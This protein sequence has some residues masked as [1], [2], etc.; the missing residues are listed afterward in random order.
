MA[1]PQKRTFGTNPYR[2]K[3]VVSTEGGCTEPEYFAIADE[4]AGHRVILAVL[5]DQKHPSPPG[6]LARMRQC[7]IALRPGDGL[8]C[9]LD[10]DHWTDAQLAEARAWA[11]AGPSAGVSRHLALSNPKFELWL[12]LHFEEVAGACGAAECVTRL[13]RHLPGYDKHLSEPDFPPERIRRAVARASCG[14]DDPPLARTGTNVHVLVK[15]I[16]GER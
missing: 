6:I 12:L 14:G 7:R 11:D 9:V 2:R 8:W 1:Y 16:L 3:I 5:S 10:R 13:K 15:A 4:A